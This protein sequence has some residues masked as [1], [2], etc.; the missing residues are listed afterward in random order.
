[1]QHQLPRYRGLYNKTHD[2]PAWVEEWDCADAR[3]PQWHPH[4]EGDAAYHMVCSPFRVA[5]SICC[6]SRL[7]CTIK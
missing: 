1:M 3:S 5:S 2:C 7:L 6:T 4:P